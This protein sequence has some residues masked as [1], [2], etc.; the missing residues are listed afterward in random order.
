MIRKIIKIDE[1]KC[2][3]C[4]AYAACHEG[5]IEM[6]NGKAKLTREYYCDGFGNCLTCISQLFISFLF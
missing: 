1:E 3:G 5:A 4:G 6:I 2:N